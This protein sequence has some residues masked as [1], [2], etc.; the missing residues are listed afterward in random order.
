MFHLKNLFIMN[1]TMRY[2]NSFN[3]SILFYIFVWT[4]TRHINHSFGIAESK[5]IV[6]LLQSIFVRRHRYMRHIPTLICSPYSFHPHI[7]VCI[8]TI[9]GRYLKIVFLYRNVNI[10]LRGRTASK[11]DR[12]CKCKHKYMTYTW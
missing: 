2:C 5:R 4:K 12:N 3:E 11:K 1:C 9:Q 7:A 10:S 8:R 6:H